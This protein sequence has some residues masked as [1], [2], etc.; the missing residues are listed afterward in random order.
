MFSSADQE[1]NLATFNIDA[2]RHVFSEPPAVYPT[3]N[4][5]ALVFDLSDPDEYFLQKAREELR[6]TPEII[7]QSIKELTELLAGNENS[8]VH[9]I[10]DNR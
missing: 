10:I 6:E 1:R 4:E 8:I 3:I 9:M 5:H 7:A 2:M